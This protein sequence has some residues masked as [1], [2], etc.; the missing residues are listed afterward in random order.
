MKALKELMYTVFT[1]KNEILF[2]YKVR[3]MW[4]YDYEE[5]TLNTAKE[6]FSVRKT[7]S[8]RRKKA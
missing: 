3:S 4:S 5:I 7:N 8:L 2:A 1:P 6:V